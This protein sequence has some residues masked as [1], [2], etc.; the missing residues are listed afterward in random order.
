[1]GQTMGCSKLP[2]TRRFTLSAWAGTPERQARR[3]ANTGSPFLKRLVPG[4][5]CLIK[6][7][8]TFIR[9]NSVLLISTVGATDRHPR[10]LRDDR[11]ER[12]RVFDYSRWVPLKEGL[13]HVN[14]G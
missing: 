14:D 7:S 9:R 4:N 6:S 3:M 5:P 2:L 12:S 13:L 10:A 11:I 1:M 8:G